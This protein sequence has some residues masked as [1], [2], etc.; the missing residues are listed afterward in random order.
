LFT[1]AAT[2]LAVSALES[3]ANQK[4]ASKGWLNIPRTRVQ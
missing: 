2:I 1:L 4:S 3:S